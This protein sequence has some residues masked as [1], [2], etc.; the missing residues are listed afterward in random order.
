MLSGLI[1][2]A[3]LMGLGGVPHCAAMCGLA[4]AA[5]LPKGVPLLTLLGRALGY[6]TLGA[7]A[8]GSAGWISQWGRE[9]AFLKPLWA[10]ALL[11]C[12]LLGVWIGLTGSM[13][14][15]FD[16]LGQALFTRLR[17]RLSKGRAPAASQAGRPAPVLDLLAGLLW[18]VLP[19]GLL[20][21]AVMVAALAASPWEGA[22]VMLAFAAP[23][24]LGVWAAPRVWAWLTRRSPTTPSNAPRGSAPAPITTAGAVVPVVWLSR[25]PGLTPVPT[26][27]PG[28]VDAAVSGLA[29]PQWAIRLGGW[30]MALMG[31][32]AAYHQLMAQ[33]RAWCA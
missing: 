16:G 33:W 10:M 28:S 13:P 27:A 11:S 3:M 21:A 14:A 30:M 2:T 9:V 4:C 7:V 24:G 8:A 19:C 20:Y 22:V 17:T 6:A 32:W 5:A 25:G 18:A 1:V 15:Q 23:S 29:N 12:C 26:P 31:G